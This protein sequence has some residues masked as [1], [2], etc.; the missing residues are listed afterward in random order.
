MPEPVY[1]SPEAFARMSAELGR[2][3]D[4]RSAIAERLSMAREY[5]NTAESGEYETTRDEQAL[6]EGEIAKLELYLRDAVLVEAGSTG[7]RI[8]IGSTVIVSSE[9]GDETYLIVGTHEADPARGLVSDVSPM[10]KA[11]MGKSA[12]DEAV[13]AAPSGGYKVTVLS[14]A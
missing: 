4:D 11:L 14:V 3:R 12:G 5:G 7:G 10:G 9:D 2:R 8:D 1:L 6:N 13:I